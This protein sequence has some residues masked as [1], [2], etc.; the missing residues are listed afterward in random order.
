[1]NIGPTD[2]IVTDTRAA[3]SC[4][5]TLGE[6]QGIKGLTR[7]QDGGDGTQA[8]LVVTE[9]TEPRRF[10]SWL[11]RRCLRLAVS[12]GSIASWSLPMQQ[13]LTVKLLEVFYK[14]IVWLFGIQAYLTNF[15]KITA[16]LTKTSSLLS[17]YRVT[18]QHPRWNN[19]ELLL[20]LTI[21]NWF[22]TLTYLFVVMN[23][24]QSNILYSNSEKKRDR[25]E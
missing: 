25:G 1:V 6:K 19:Q 13:L 16:F 5:T 18:W 11:W 8:R 20:K 10:C 7:E 4:G 23:L 15:K 2:P 14:Y 9:G 22:S 17:N 24:F 12:R 21:Q 3:S